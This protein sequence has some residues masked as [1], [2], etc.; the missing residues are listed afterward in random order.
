V[1]SKW[2]LDNQRENPKGL[3]RPKKRTPVKEVVGVV[4]GGGPEL[5][6]KSIPRA[7][8]ARLEGREPEDG[9]ACA[10]SKRKD[11][12]NGERGTWNKQ[13]STSCT[14]NL[15]KRDLRVGVQHGLPHGREKSKKAFFEWR[16]RAIGV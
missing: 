13:R 16:R 10:R 8:N 4:G 3:L 11:P 14:S 6:S 12:T 2:G 9:G 7:V 5:A 15:I 1:R